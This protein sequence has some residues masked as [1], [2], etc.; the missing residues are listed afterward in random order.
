MAPF[1]PSST[2]AK[3]VIVKAPA[4][5]A[6]PPLDSISTAPHV[7]PTAATP[8]PTPPS[9]PQIP[10]KTAS[11]TA[12]HAP[13]PPTALLARTTT[14]STNKTIPAEQPVSLQGTSTKP[15]TTDYH[16]LRA[17]AMAAVYY[18]YPVPLE[19]VLFVLIPP[20]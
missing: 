17:M 6:T 8:P 15:S 9:T 13:M 11:T 2:I 19:L 4:S 14:T 1:L 20:S 18:A 5:P 16:A 7:S 12:L 10:A 3:P